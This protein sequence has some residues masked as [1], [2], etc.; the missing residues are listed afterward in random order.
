[1][2]H[3]PIEVAEISVNM[4]TYSDEHKHTLLTNMQS[5]ITMGIFTSGG[6]PLGDEHWR[7]EL[8]T[9][10]RASRAEKPTTIRASAR[11][12]NRVTDCFSKDFGRREYLSGEHI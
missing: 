2:N 1:M 12:G 4:T 3:G 8:I 5:V 10:W 11:I 9:R 7:S 6:N